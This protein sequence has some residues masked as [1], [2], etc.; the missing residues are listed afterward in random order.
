MDDGPDLTDLPVLLIYD[1]NWKWEKSEIDFTLDKIDK[2]EQGIRALGH[3]LWIERIQDADLASPLRKYNP[4]EVVVYNL[5]EELPGIPRSASV[6]AQTLER[7]NFIHTGTTA[8]A[9]AFNQDK[10]KVKRTLDLYGIPTPQWHVYRT[11][12]LNGWKRYPAIVKP[13]L[14]HCSVGVNVTSVVNNRYELRDRVDYV[15]ETYHQFALV[16]DFVDGREFRVSV[17][18]NERPQMLPPGEMDYSRLSQVHERLLSYESKMDPES[19]YYNAIGVIQPVSLSES[20]LQ[21]MERIAIGAYRAALCRDYGGID[22]RLR[23]GQFYVLDVNADP[24]IAPHN[25]MTGGAQML[26]YNFGQLASH[27]INMAARRHPVFCTQYQEV[28]CPA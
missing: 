18:G 10:R 3:P 25:T 12:R 23:D 7:M 28:A 26:G 14:E 13:P 21:Q 27:I 15:L 6:V 2:L 17:W 19:I 4:K 5:C 24:E 22:I 8:E 16:E 1:L 11:A 9:L 20:Q